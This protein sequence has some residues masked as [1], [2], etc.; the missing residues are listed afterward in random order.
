M[1]ITEGFMVDK[2]VYWPLASAAS[3]NEDYGDYGLP[4]WSTPVE[5]DVR[6]HEEAVE[7][8]GPDG[9]KQVSRATVMTTS[10]LAVGG[11]LWHGELVSV[12]DLNNPKKNDGAW[13][14][15]GWQ[16]IPEP[17]GESYFRQAFL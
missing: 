14:I 9:D 3:G 11:V 4:Q 1:G 12:S 17:D 6:W 8:I 16:K 13:E 10:D 15:R 2:A 5:I 7:F